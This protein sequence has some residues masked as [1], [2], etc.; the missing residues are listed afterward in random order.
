MESQK[1]TV[2]KNLAKGNKTQKTKRK[3]RP[4]KAIK[5]KKAIIEAKKRKK[6]EERKIIFFELLGALAITS[7]LVFLLSVFLFSLPKIEGY[8]MVPTLRE[9]D[10]VYVN[11]LG[12]LKTFELVYVQIP[13]K[14]AKEVRRIIGLPGQKIT[15]KNDQLKIDG[16]DREEKFIFEEQQTS[17]ENGRL[18]T[19]D[20]S[21]FSLTEKT[22]IPKGKYLLLGDNRPYSVDS[23]QYGL[24]DQKDIIGVVEMRIL[25][26]HLFQNF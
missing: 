2:K 7:F 26:L 9:G 8:S 4:K 25:P 6:R 14:K 17:Q 13:G 1:R 12:K 20:F 23:R 19:D 11:K 16:E 21:I 5:S 22:E 15:Y 10:R 18:Y 24:V 3:K